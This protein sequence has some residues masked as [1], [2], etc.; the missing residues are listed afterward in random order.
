MGV[1]NVPAATVEFYAGAPNANAPGE[2]LSP[3]LHRPQCVVQGL[4][5]DGRRDR[6]LNGGTPMSQSFRNL[7]IAVKLGAP[8]LAVVL[9]CFAGFALLISREAHHSAVEQTLLSAEQSI[10]RLKLLRGYYAKNVVAPVKAASE[11]K[12]HFEH[13][14]RSDTIPLPATMLHDLSRLIREDGQNT[15]LRLYSRYPFPNRAGR[16]LDVFAQDALTF[17]EENPD[18]RFAREEETDEGTLIRL[19]ISDKMSVQACVTCHNAHPDTP[20]ADWA[21]GDVRGVLEVSTRVD[22]QLAAVMGG[23]VRSMAGGLALIALLAVGGVAFPALRAIRTRLGRLAEQFESAV[24]GD[25]TRAIHSESRDE[26]GQI[27]DRFA[28]LVDG[29]REGLGEIHD[30]SEQVN[31]AADVLTSV[32]KAMASDV[33]TTTERYDSASE[34][35]QQLEQ[36]IGVVAGAVE[37]SS[38]HVRDVAAAIE[39]TSTNLSEINRSS[40]EIQGDVENVVTSLDTMRDSLGAL[41]Q[42]AESAAQ[43]TNNASQSAEQ[44]N[45]IVKVL[46]SSASEIGKVVDTINDIAGQTNLLALNATIEAASAGEAGRGFAV[47]ANEVKELAKQTAQSTDDIRT[48]VEEMQQNTGRSIE[49]IR[50]IVEA[51][52][53]INVVS[54]GIADEVRAQGDAAQQVSGLSRSLEQSSGV[55]THNVEQ[56]YTG[57]AQI[58]K[59]CAELANGSNEIASGAA[60][61]SEQ[62]HSVSSLLAE[63]SARIRGNSESTQKVDAAA[64]EL[65]L[66]AAQLDTV[67]NRFR[68]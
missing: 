20:K 65:V 18:E 57:S 3:S 58:S 33:D 49:A 52:E 23:R 12:V 48:R 42:R 6:V 19:A 51:I 37:E 50:E 67:V 45:D 25:L 16:E 53:E 31:R 27:Q 11:M 46:G 59:T 26:V 1:E 44:A 9:L 17:L 55:I 68:V 8:L 66:L 32:S 30:R 4:G 64:E 39:E 54:Q 29:L 5:P 63:F 15:V 60:H 56:A 13:A 34:S 61:A 41:V 22:P 43:M 24:E 35:F 14:D 28:S 47:V 38:A 62:A 40:H 7:S 2:A 10:H 36:G 21:L